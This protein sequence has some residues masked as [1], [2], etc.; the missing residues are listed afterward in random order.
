MAYVIGTA[1]TEAAWLTTLSRSRGDGFRYGLERVLDGL[2][3]R[4]G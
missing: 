1:T 4:L 3:T 2:E